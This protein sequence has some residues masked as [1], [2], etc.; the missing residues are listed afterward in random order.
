MNEVLLRTV[1]DSYNRAIKKN[2]NLC[3]QENTMIYL[4]IMKHSNQLTFKWFRK[5]VLKGGK[6]RRVRKTEG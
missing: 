4:R 2:K 3:S 5:I 1:V 6:E